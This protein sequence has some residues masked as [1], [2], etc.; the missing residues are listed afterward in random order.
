MTKKGS[1][2]DI[3]DKYWKAQI[4]KQIRKEYQE[5]LD[6]IGAPKPHN[7]NISYLEHALRHLNL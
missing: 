5:Y 7:R 6:G 4:E 2:K 3:S 1:Q